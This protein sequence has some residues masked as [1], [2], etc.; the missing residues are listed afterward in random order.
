MTAGALQLNF[1]GPQDKHL[2]GN[3]QMTYFK[4]VYKKYSNFKRYKNIIENKVQLVQNIY[5]LY[6]MMVIY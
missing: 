3:P 4:S 5:V 6:R 1:I 2:T